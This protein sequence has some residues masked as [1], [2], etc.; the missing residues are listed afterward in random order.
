MHVNIDRK[1]LIA[2]LQECVSVIAK[3]PTIPILNNVKLLAENDTLFISAT[4]LEIS[5]SLQ[6]PAQVVRPG[7]ITTPANHLLGLVKLQSADRTDLI[8]PDSEDEESSY[9]YVRSGKSK[10]QTKTMPAESYPQ[11]HKLPD[12]MTQISATQFLLAIE[13]VENSM[14]DTDA[15]PYFNAIYSDGKVFVATNG[16]K[17]CR[18]DFVAPRMLIPRKAVD[19]IKNFLDGFETALMGV[20]ANR[21]YL[22]CADNYISCA[23]LEPDT[24]PQ[25]W[26]SIFPESADRFA[27]IS[28]DGLMEALKR[29]ALVCAD[30]TMGVYFKLDK[31]RLRL[32]SEN[33]DVGSGMEEVEAQYEGR[34]TTLGINCANLRLLI[35][36]WPC[37]ALKFE[38]QSDDSYPIIVRPEKN[39]GPVYFGLA[40]PMRL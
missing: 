14:E 12:N 39:E 30:K 23:L 2:G 19:I 16:A 5:I 20:E 22:K 32:E 9:L 1:S 26:E 4:N 7:E 28:K 34:E 25:A 21:L 6:Y 13:R 38:F 37:Q 24:F 40:M 3:K 31:N 15:R 27:I 36:N 10:H 11:I 18:S 33:A 17:L 35:D 29:I 8:L